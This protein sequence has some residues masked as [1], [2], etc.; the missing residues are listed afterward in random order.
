MAGTET[1]PI[2]WYSPE[3]MTQLLAFLGYGLDPSLP[4][5]SAL[6]ATYFAI[7][8]VRPFIRHKGR[9]VHMGQSRLGMAI[10]TLAAGVMIPIQALAAFQV[11][12]F[13]ALGL[14]VLG[15]AWLLVLAGITFSAALLSRP[16]AAQQSAAPDSA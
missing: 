13:P 6:L 10:R 12:P 1:L 4:T 7:S 5:L 15:C 14:Y 16:H 9:T 8:F 3:G 2:R 11:L